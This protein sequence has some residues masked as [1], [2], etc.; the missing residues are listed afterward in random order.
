[1]K[2]FEKLAVK[3]SLTKAEITLVSVLLGFLVLGGVLKNIRSVEKAETLVKKVETARYREEEVD[4]LL[5]LASMAQT[6]V[7]EDVMEG[8]QRDK[9][10]S[11]NE[12]RGA[13]HSSEKKLFNGTISFNKASKGQLQKIPGVGPVMAERLMTFRTAK[14]G[15]VHA[16]QEFLE[17]KGVGEKKLEFLKKYFTLE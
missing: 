6:E 13:H 12:K 15:K 7:K 16:F 3:L 10:G 11:S 4:S 1:M 5:A 9:E 8:A 2:L 14:G 17:V